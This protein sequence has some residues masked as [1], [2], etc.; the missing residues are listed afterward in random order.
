[1]TGT[2]QPLKPLEK[3]VQKLGQS[4]FSDFDEVNNR[5]VQDSMRQAS[6]LVNEASIQDNPRTQY[7]KPFYMNKRTSL[8]ADRKS[9]NVNIKDYLQQTGM[10]SVKFG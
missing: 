7:D 2:V 6:T 3:S 8:P 10:I 1:M 4:N 5:T 9:G